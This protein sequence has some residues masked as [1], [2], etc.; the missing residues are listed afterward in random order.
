MRRLVLPLL[1]LLSALPARAEDTTAATRWKPRAGASFAI[2]LSVA[3]KTITTTA[4][5]VDV[6]LFD[7]DASTIAALKSQGKHTVCYF[8]AG[9]WEN[10]RPDAAKFPAAVKGKAYSGWAGERWL[11]IRR[12]DILGPIMTARMDLCKAKGFDAVDPD[13]VEDVDTWGNVTGFHLKR[14]DNILYVQRLAAAAHARGLAFGLKN[15]AE[16]SRDGRVFTV[17]DFTVTED[18]FDQGWCNL[19]K[20]FVTAGKPVFALEYTD[21]HIDFAAFCKQAKT[22]GLSPLLKRR[23]L[24]AWEKR[25][26]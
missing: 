19:S 5:V 15:A 4:A 16:M 11:D 26:P 2:L 9:S 20:N 1:A 6:D 22:L 18:C 7:I 13:N 8:S 10:W 3:P 17:S 14:A 25:C 23:N 24:D 21:N 12:W